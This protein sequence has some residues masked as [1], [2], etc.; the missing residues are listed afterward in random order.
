MNRIVI[1]MYKLAVGWF[2]KQCSNL[3]NMKLKL[4]AYYV[5]NPQL[6]IL[7]YTPL[8]ISANHASVFQ[9]PYEENT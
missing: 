8:S 4:S 2:S 7:K 1:D 3:I 6:C 5:S 9:G